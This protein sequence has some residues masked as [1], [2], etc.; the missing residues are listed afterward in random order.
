MGFGMSGGA[1]DEAITWDAENDRVRLA[2]WVFAPEEASFGEV[3]IGEN[4]EDG[5][6]TI[7]VASL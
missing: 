7:S 2:E 3:E 6:A 4:V 1:G 5:E